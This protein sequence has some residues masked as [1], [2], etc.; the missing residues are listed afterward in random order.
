[1]LRSAEPAPASTRV[2][3]KENDVKAIEQEVSDCETCLPE[4]A[5]GIEHSLVI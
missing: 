3:T 5:P 1:M 4:I 2:Q